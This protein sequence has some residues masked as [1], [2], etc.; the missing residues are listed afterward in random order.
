M[1]TTSQTYNPILIANYFVKKSLDEDVQLTPMKLVKLVYIAHGW[2]L[3]L[4][5]RPLLSET[6][7]AWKYGP[8]LPSIYHAFKQYGADQINE[9]AVPGNDEF[10]EIDA[11]T[12]ELLDNVWGA[13][14]NYTGS[15]LSTI[16]HMVGTPWDAATKDGKKNITD[17]AIKA[18][19][20]NLNNPKSGH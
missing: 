2:N 5:D 13:Y 3:A 20:K 19:Y 14:K 10:E 8:V 18:H 17:D 16:T 11:K 4:Q 7:Q 15:Q 9:M 1:E 6:V 12:R